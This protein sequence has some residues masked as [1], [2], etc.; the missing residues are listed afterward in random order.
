MERVAVIG[1]GPAGLSAASAL[2]RAGVGVTL[3]EE[4]SGAGGRMRSDELD[5]AM[6]DVAVQLFSSTYA[7]LHEL[8]ARAGVGDRLV[9]SPGRDALWRGGRAHVITYGSVASMVTS[10]ALPNL[11][12]LRLAAKYLPFLA[13][14]AR[15]LD[16]NDPAGSGGVAFDARSIAAWGREHIGED[17]VELLVYPLLAA[18]YGG[19]PEQTSA[20]VY[21]ALARVGM[22]VKVLAVRG[23]MSTLADGIAEALRRD[24]VE[25]RMGV[26]V[27][28]I[29]SAPGRVDVHWPGGS[30]AFDG[31]VVAVPPGVARSLVSSTSD[32][33]DRWLA[34]VEMLPTAT[35]ALR[36]E[37]RL[38]TGW[39]GLSFPR[40]STTGEDVVALCVQS[41]KAPEMI[42][43]DG[44]ALV[45]FPAP[46]IAARMA[47]ADSAEVVETL[48]PAVERVLPGIRSRIR[49]A[50]VHRFAEGYTLFRP[51]HLR[52]LREYDPGWV[53]GVA[54]AG[55]YLVAP[56]V[57]GAVISG[58]R[59]ASHLLR[60]R[61][62]AGPG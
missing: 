6:V 34:G 56:T 59:A 51:G 39:F 33:L 53:E 38:E 1:A 13:G 44:D 55:D 42:R 10:S 9:K 48:V 19:V 23:G 41:A 15:N 62:A 58:R 26:G 35:L 57:E 61:T 31:V 14:E 7:R 30:D 50:R 2:V 18:Y 45:V 12:K 54:M 25:V 28:R 22:E 24:G 17:F 36:V 46:R 16:A 32:A 3:L 60:S 27:E 49:R 4:R 47:A 5:G 52:H 8:A 40:T 29:E 43:T 11:L 21:H 20:A 37:K